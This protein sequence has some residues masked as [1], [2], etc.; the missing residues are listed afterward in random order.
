MPVP[1]PETER[2][3]TWEVDGKTV[4]LV[5]VGLNADGQVESCSYIG[6]YTGHE[7]P[8]QDVLDHYELE[9]YVMP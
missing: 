8:I 6:D 4:D 1:Q 9:T 2:T 5:L 7:P 3:L